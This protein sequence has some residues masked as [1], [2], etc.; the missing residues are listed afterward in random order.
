MFMKVSIP[1]DGGEKIKRPWTARRAPRPEVA[2]STRGVDAQREPGRG[3]INRG[4]KDDEWAACS[5][6]LAG[7]VG[8]LPERLCPWF[9][10]SL[11]EEPAMIMLPAAGKRVGTRPLSCP[12]AFWL[13]GLT[14]GPAFCSPFSLFGR[15]DRDGARRDRSRAG[16]SSSRPVTPGRPSPCGSA[17]FSAWSAW[18]APG[19]GMR[20]GG[21]PTRKTWPSVPSTAF[22]AMPNAAVSR[23]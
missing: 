19:C 6:P 21:W 8:H 17:I 18:L 12:V 9:V 22:A 10:D 16:C 5:C 23:N 4:V 3:Q 14:I 7:P 2:T 20:H 15:A 13:R 11:F 1:R